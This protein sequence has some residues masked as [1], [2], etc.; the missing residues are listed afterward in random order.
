MRV[1]IYI[2]STWRRTFPAFHR[3]QPDSRL[4]LIWRRQNN[5]KHGPGNR[6]PATGSVYIK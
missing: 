6:E 1:S 2:E 3:I 5:I 4:R